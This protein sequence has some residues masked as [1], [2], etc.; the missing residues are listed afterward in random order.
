MPLLQYPEGWLPRKSEGRA[1]TS[2]PWPPRGQRGTVL[3]VID[4]IRRSERCRLCGNLAVGRGTGGA[5]GN[6]RSIRLSYGIG[7]AYLDS[8]SGQ[9]PLRGGELADAGRPVTGGPL[10]GRRQQRH[11]LRRLGVSREG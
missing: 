5:L 9:T 6:R 7:F 10:H 8:A 11:R 3:G 4:A 2:L 1:G